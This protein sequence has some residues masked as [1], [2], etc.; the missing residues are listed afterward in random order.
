MILDSVLHINHSAEYYIDKI[1]HVGT[2]R[3]EYIAKVYAHMWPIEV[4]HVGYIAPSSTY[5]YLA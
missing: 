4:L 2:L 1:I 5:L 3:T